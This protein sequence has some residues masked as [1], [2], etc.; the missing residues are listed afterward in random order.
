MPSQSLFVNQAKATSTANVTL[1]GLDR[2]RCRDGSF[3]TISLN[4][5]NRFNRCYETVLPDS[6]HSQQSGEPSLGKMRSQNAHQMRQTSTIPLKGNNYFANALK[7]LSVQQATYLKTVIYDMKGRHEGRPH[8]VPLNYDWA[9][10]PRIGMGNNPQ[11]FKA[12]I[13]WGQLYEAAEGN[14]AT[15]TR[16]QIKDIQAY[17]LSKRDGHW[18]LLQRSKRVQGDAYREDFVEDINQPAD[19]RSEPDGRISVKAGDGYNFHFWP[20]NGRV[21]IDP[22]DIQGL[23]TT[24]KARLVVDDPLEPDDRPQAKYVLSAGGDY[25]KNLTV[26]WDHL[27]TN[28]DAGIGK[29][30]YVKSEW[31][32]FNMTTLSPTQLRFSPPPNLFR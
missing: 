9:S 26:P 4:R 18:H 27:K 17:V 20:K 3:H 11:G 29:F 30:K 28:G 12:F 15:N 22:Q 14:P 5:F 13:S 1:G 7:P 2:T 24:V 19:I 8:G 32:S 10:R 23:L 6:H 16:V 25:W 31:Q 21:S